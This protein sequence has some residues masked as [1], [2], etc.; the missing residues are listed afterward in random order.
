MFRLSCCYFMDYRNETEIIVDVR[1]NDRINYDRTWKNNLFNFFS[2]VT[3]KLAEDL[4]KPFKLERLRRID[5][6]PVHKAV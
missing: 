2:K 5:E 6:T 4:P 3:P 1:W